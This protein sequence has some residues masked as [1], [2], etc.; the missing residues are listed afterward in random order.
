MEAHQTSNLGV[1]GSSP[2]RV[3]CFFP[4]INNTNTIF[5]FLFTFITF[6][7][8]YNHNIKI[9][10]F[11]KDALVPNY[12]RFWFFSFFIEKVIIIFLFIE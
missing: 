4:N 8:S 11:E 7:N 3:E 1:L 2:S 9:N 5:M 12:I 6:N 10:F